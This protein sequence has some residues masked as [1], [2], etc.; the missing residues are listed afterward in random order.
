MHK[1][2]FISTHVF[3]QEHSR[4]SSECDD[5]ITQTVNEVYD[6]ITLFSVLISNTINVDRHNPHK[7]MFFGVLNF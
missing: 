5:I 7:H 2:L 3:S 4:V 6:C 1:Q